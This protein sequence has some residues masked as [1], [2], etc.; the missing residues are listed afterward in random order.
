MYKQKVHLKIYHYF[1]QV[2]S[3]LNKKEKLFF[4][5]IF[6]TSHDDDPEDIFPPSTTTHHSVSPLHKQ[7]SPKTSDTSYF[8]TDLKKK[9][10][11]N[12]MMVNI[13]SIHMKIKN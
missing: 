2:H 12:H 8:D 5:L 1:H 7:A 10:L 3:M 4:G 13:I 9:Y 11:L 6:K